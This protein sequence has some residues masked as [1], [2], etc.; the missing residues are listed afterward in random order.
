MSIPRKICTANPRSDLSYAWAELIVLRAYLKA[1][2]EVKIFKPATLARFSKNNKI[3]FPTILNKKL[4]TWNFKFPDFIFPC[5][6]L[7]GNIKTKTLQF[8]SKLISIQMSQDF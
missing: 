4:T 3:P 7:S 5:H 2:T 6:I 8:N 1:L